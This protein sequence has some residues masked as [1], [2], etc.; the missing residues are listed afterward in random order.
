MDALYVVSQKV[1]IMTYLAVKNKIKLLSR[2][3]YNSESKF[4]RRR[5]E[6]DNFS[7]I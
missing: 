1:E 7:I 4:L 3:L 6:R 5:I 2:L